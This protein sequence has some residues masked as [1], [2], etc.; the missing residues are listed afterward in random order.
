M[1]RN[2]KILSFGTQRSDFR[3]RNTKR[4][5]FKH[6]N[7][8]GGGS[9]GS[10]INVT[11][12]TFCVKS[13]Y[14]PLQIQIQRKAQRGGGLPP[15]LCG[16]S[17]RRTCPS[18]QHSTCLA[19]QQGRCLGSQQGTCLASQQGIVFWPGRVSWENKSMPC[20]QAT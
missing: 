17:E 19:S 2:C 14:F 4:F 16:G 20:L 8:R 15:P 5:H 11:D 10:K 12:S 18:S 6:P 3:G 1:C 7:D 13:Q 9:T